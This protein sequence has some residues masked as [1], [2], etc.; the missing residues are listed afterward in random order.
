MHWGIQN[1]LQL[2]R[3]KVVF[4]KHNDMDSLRSKL[5]EI[6][7]GNKRAKKLRRYIVVEA[8][9]QVSPFSFAHQ[10]LCEMLCFCERFVGSSS[11]I[12]SRP[13]LFGNSWFF[14][15]LFASSSI[16]AIFYMIH[17]TCKKGILSSN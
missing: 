10:H 13:V 14:H 5:E 9:Y 2:S 15:C 3:S 4:F 16:P 8:I 6:T 17:P 7:A 11:E 12:Q 1:G